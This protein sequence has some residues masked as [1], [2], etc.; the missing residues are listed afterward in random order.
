MPGFFDAMRIQ[1]R[2]RVPGWSDVDQRTQAV[3]VTQALADRLWPGEDPIGRG[4]NSNGMTSTNWYDVVGVVAELHAEALDRPPIEAVFYAPTDFRPNTRNGALNELTYM[5]RT[6]G[7]SPLSLVPAIRR[8]LT[9]MNPRVPFIEPRTMEQVASR[10]MARTSFV[11]AM[12]GLAAAVALSLSV[13]GTYGVV[14]YLVSQRRGEIG[15]R[16]ALGAQREAVSRMVVAESL[17]LGLAGAAI[18]VAGAFAANRLLATLL[19]NVSPTDPMVLAAAA[20]L[21]VSFAALAALVPARRAAGT[22]P[23]EALRG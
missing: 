17:R 7:I 3:V 20:L 23:I 8:V 5:V 4:I 21:L 10:S 6:E 16:I 22:E 9:G 18:G 13:V 1:V 19:F 14:S 2:G 15:V 12:L 11:M